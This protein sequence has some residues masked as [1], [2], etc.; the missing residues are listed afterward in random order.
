MTHFDNFRQWFR[1]LHDS[2]KIDPYWPIQPNI[3]HATLASVIKDPQIAPYLSTTMVGLDLD[4]TCRSQPLS[5]VYTAR[6]GEMTYD[7]LALLEHL[8]EKALRLVV[9]TNQTM[10]GHFFA[11]LCS[12]LFGYEAYPKA[13]NDRKIPILGASP[14]LPGLATPYKA[15]RAALM[16][17]TAAIQAGEIPKKLIIVGDKVSDVAFANMLWQYLLHETNLKLILEAYLLTPTPPVR[18]REPLRP[19]LVP[20]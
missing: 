15:T 17:T 14:G 19:L 6:F 1:Y 11:A 13:L 12:Q 5:N 20:T 4:K 9:I 16:D 3:T 2:S 7:E 8:Q 10:S 18:V